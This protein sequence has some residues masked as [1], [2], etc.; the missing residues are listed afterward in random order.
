MLVMNINLTPEQEHLIR[1]KLETGKYRNAEEVLE[2]ALK[3]FE[4]YER[5]DAEWVEDVTTK[6]DAAIAISHNRQ[7]IDGE[8]FIN[9]ILTRFQK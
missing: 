2:I 7:P 6:I 3:L 1:T 4:E 9:D 5:S 8:S